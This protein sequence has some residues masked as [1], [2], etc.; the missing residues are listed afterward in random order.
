MSAR[1]LAGAAGQRSVELVTI[2][3]LGPLAR[4]A[5]PGAAVVA[6]LRSGTVL[7]DRELGRG[8]F[9]ILRADAILRPDAAAGA[10]GARWTARDIQVGDTVY[11]IAE[12]LGAVWVAERPPVAPR[13]L[14]E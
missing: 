1:R 8:Q 12:P 2:V 5:L 4:P 11:W 10:R 9:L 3:R 13:A 7:E 14:P 6:D